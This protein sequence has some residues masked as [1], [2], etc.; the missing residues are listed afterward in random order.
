[1]KQSKDGQAYEL[2]VV[3]YCRIDVHY[4]ELEDEFALISSKS[5]ADNRILR[6]RESET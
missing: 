6:L 5:T 2:E 3:L 1:M 4:C